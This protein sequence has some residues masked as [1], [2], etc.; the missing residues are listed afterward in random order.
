MDERDEN[1]MET[2][3]TPSKRYN[4]SA[5]FRALSKDPDYPCAK[6]TRVSRPV[7]CGR[8]EC[9]EYYIWFSRKW[10]RIQRALT[11]EKPRKVY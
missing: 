11:I 5:V 7:Y 9:N 6:C 3:Y 4:R 2:E 10:Q 1:E 8:L